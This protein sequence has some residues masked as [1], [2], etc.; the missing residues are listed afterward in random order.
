MKH[1]NK[2][3]KVLLIFLCLF[4]GFMAVMTSAKFANANVFKLK[5]SGQ[6]LKNEFKPGQVVETSVTSITDGDTIRI[7][8]PKWGS[9]PVRLSCI[10]APGIRKVSKEEKELAK[11]SKE[12]LKELVPA[13]SKI[14][15]KVSPQV[16]DKNSRLVA[17]I[18]KANQSINLKMVAS[19]WAVV[20]C[21][22]VVQDC[23][24]SRE[25]YNNAEISAK[26]NK[27][28]IWENNVPW[29]GGKS[30]AGC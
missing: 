14:L 12:V 23:Q 1:T 17:E 30:N 11:L 5:V 28:G 25:S 18:F 24:S 13:K 16:A 3:K 4:I 2:M 20:Q 9:I 6:Q 26:N 21:D 7:N 29:N 15:V 19:G 22:Q 8:Y 27:F 10:T